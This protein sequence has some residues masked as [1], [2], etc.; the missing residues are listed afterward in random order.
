MHVLCHPTCVMYVLNYKHYNTLSRNVVFTVMTNSTGEMYILSSAAFHK[1]HA[2]SIK[3]AFLGIFSHESLFSLNKNYDE[4][5]TQTA[6]STN[7][8][9]FSVLK[10][11]I[12][13]NIPVCKHVC[14]EGKQGLRKEDCCFIPSSPQSHNDTFSYTPAPARRGRTS[15][16]GY[17]TVS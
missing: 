10:R 14:I 12:I 13:M 1:C 4:K 2:N 8:S 15:C 11:V 3:H 16:C 7:P 9:G 17:I 6:F 5:L